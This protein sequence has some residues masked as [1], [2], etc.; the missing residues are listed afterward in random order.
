MATQMDAI[1]QMI[2][3]AKKKSGVKASGTTDSSTTDEVV[4]KRQNHKHIPD[5]AKSGAGETPLLGKKVRI[6]G[7]EYK[8]VTQNQIFDQETLVLSRDV[9]ESVEDEN[10]TIQDLGYF[11]SNDI[12]YP[13]VEMERTYKHFK[14]RRGKPITVANIDENT[15][16]IEPI[17]IKIIGLNWNDPDYFDIVYLVEDMKVTVPVN[18]LINRFLLL[19]EAENAFASKEI[20]EETEE[21]DEDNFDDLED[22]L[23]I[24]FQKLTNR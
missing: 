6:E 2:A 18:D 12:T 4:I 20:P 10:L 19:E 3:E 23:K 17:E 11:A 1:E 16:V 15:N 22:L 21:I 5:Q 9:T 14:E 13:T 8:V 24:L 7:N